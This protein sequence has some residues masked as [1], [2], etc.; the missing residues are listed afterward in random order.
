MSAKVRKVVGYPDHF[1]FFDDWAI[2]D[3]CKANGVQVIHEC[4]VGTWNALS[5]RPSDT[6]GK[7]L[8]ELTWR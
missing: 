6:E 1:W 7:L 8:F 3:W 4:S 5:I 2:W